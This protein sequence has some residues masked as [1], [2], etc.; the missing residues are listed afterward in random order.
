MNAEAQT[1]QFYEA[2]NGFGDKLG[3]LMLQLCENFS[4]KVLIT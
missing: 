3:G 4:P 1:A 2:L